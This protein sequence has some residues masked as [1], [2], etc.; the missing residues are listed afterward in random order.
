MREAGASGYVRCT[1]LGAK[2]KRVTEGKRVAAG[3]R[4]SDEGMQWSAGNEH[5][6]GSADGLRGGTR[7]H[8]HNKVQRTKV[9]SSQVQG[10]Q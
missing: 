5:E 1:G 6:D 10:K 8:P 2:G 7:V 4:G 3:G 9:Q